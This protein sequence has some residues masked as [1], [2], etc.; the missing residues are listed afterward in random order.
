MKAL[1]D[2]QKHEALCCDCIQQIYLENKQQ[3]DTE[4]TDHLA[5]GHRLA[6]RKS[7]MIPCLEEVKL[8]FVMA[9][10]HHSWAVM[11]VKDSF[12]SLHV[13]FNTSLTLRNLGV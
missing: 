7:G 3:D 10:I 11:T 8:T 1:E 5:S 13:F 4:I 2:I 12:F 9:P 6:V